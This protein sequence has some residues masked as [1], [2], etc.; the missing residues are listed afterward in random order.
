MIRHPSFKTEPWCVREAPLDLDVLAQSE[1]L[2]ALS[3]GHLGMRGNLDEGEPH[4]LP[5]TYL[6]SVYE[7]RPLPSAEPAYGSPEVGQTIINVTNGKIIRL[8]VDDELF[9]VRQG[10]LISHERLLD[11]RTG[12][13]HRS[14]EWR[15]PAGGHVALRS[16]RL[17]SLTQR[18]VAAISWE[19]TAVGR[20]VG[21]VVESELVANEELPPADPDP[22]SAP[23]LANVLDA[24]EH[25]AGPDGEALLMHTVRRS[26]IRL[27]AAM[28][29][30]VEAP[31][32][33]VFRLE[34]S[35][36]VAQATI[37]SRL[38]PGQTLRV[39]KY[40]AYG[41]STEL[42]QPALRDQVHGA[43]ALARHTGWHQLCDDQ[44]RSLDAFWS[45]ADVSVAGDAEVQQ[46]VRLSLFHLLQAAVRAEGQPI[47]A[48]GLTGP[49][50]EG[51][52]FWDTEVY[53]LPVL[54]STFPQ[55]VRDALEWRKSTLPTARA[56]ASLL[57]LAGAAFPWRT[58]AGQES[59]GYWPAGTAAFH[60]NAGI[61]LSA[62]RYVRATGD[63]DFERKVGLELLVE[64]ARMWR[65]LGHHDKNGRF[66]ID[67]VTG[68]DE[69][70][71]IADNNLYT[72]LMAQQ[73]L[74]Q[75]AEAVGR[76]PGWA[77]AL[78][79]TNEETAAWLDAAR[80]MVIPYD[81][82]LEIHL[83]SEGYT[84]H[85]VWDFEHTKP[86]QYPLF[87]HFPYF[88]LY[89][90]QVV[91]QADLVLA[92]YQVSDA[93]TEEQKARN[94]DYY[95]RLNVRDSSLSASAQGIIAA[96][97]G[98]LDLAYAYLYESAMIDLADVQH[99]T[100]NGL[101]LAAL[102]GSW[103]ILVAGFG[104][105]RLE[106][107]VLSF[108]P[109]L[110]PALSALTFNLLHRGRHLRVTVLS[111]SARYELVDGDPLALRHHGTPTEVF[112]ERPVE[113]PTPPAPQR[114]RPTQPPGRA[115]A[116]PRSGHAGW[117]GD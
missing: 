72:N 15:S 21:I 91:K 64:T 6:N 29:H 22:R 73:N 20:S 98:H 92:M 83:Q 71:A 36:D 113:L 26:G 109:R 81:E 27:G 95:E 69:Y 77:A 28:V 74:R 41:W 117:G 59:S 56:R 16:T 76:H 4:G 105:L 34:T 7:L 12:L 5:G 60:V 44:R 107:E 46:A 108:A 89:R 47:P 30:D 93:F 103:M 39:V 33:P 68:P 114:P 9:D 85:A 17:V 1:S 61:A 18:A 13:L 111:T 78:H 104:G 53:V 32:P 106:S 49:G 11:L 99:D 3:N 112:R 35:D 97:L 63:M 96:E 102:A 110:P 50:Y 43:L 57:G 70:G 54:T 84:E 24:L 101:H 55:P 88:D 45:H 66:R 31:Q 48:K 38:D 8:L 90:K 14:V 25:R 75:A 87:L 116:V 86:E 42:S 10:E 19:V 58:I 23:M 79:V 80:A 94:F 52:T 51:H 65:S 67:G 100:R 37:I 115:P 40:L 2:F 62:V 82:T